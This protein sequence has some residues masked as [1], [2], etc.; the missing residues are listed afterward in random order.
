MANGDDARPRIARAPGM[1]CVLLMALLVLA[2]VPAHAV[3]IVES[4][5]L[6]VSMPEVIKGD[7]D[8]ALANFGV[9][10]YGGELRWASFSPTAYLPLRTGFRRFAEGAAAAS[11]PACR[12]SASAR[13]AS[14]RRPHT[15]VGQRHVV[16]DGL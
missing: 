13:S 1:S 3:F 10:S 6:K 12:R 16:A 11:E 8:I 15:A 9:P 4:G 14:L 5:S 7:Y 2:L